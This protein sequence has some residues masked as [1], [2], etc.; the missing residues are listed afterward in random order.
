MIYSFS[1]LI[2]FWEEKI[3]DNY[4]NILGSILN[5]FS[6]WEEF[7]KSILSISNIY[8]KEKLELWKV[9]ISIQNKENFNKALQ[10]ILEKKDI[11]I[12]WKMYVIKWVDFNFSIFE[13]NLEFRDYKNIEITFKTPTIIKKEIAWIDINQLLPVPEIFLVSAIRK[14]N[15]LYTKNLDLDEIKKQIKN[16]IIVVSFDIMTKLV[17]IKWNNKAGVIWKIKY[18]IL[19]WLDLETK[20]ILYNALNLTKLVWIWTGNRLWLGQVWVYFSK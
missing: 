2:D 18:E 8:S 14:Y 20:I 17:K 19:S 1:I 10:I 7:K 13:D 3:Q 9:S 11:N 15:I 4:Y 12:N 5:L 16:N 6:S